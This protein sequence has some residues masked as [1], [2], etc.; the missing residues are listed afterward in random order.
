VLTTPEVPPSWTAVVLSGGRGSRLG[1]DKAAVLIDEVS[2]MN[3]VLVSLP[4]AIH[5]IVVGP[6]PRNPVRSVTVTRESPI[7]G[8]P[9]AALAAGLQL[10]T[11]TIVA[12][13]ATDMPFAGRLLARL[14][15][16]LPAGVDALMPI[17]TAGRRQPL[18]AAYRTTALRSA[19]SLLGDPNGAS[20]RALT[21]HLVVSEILIEDDTS[22]HDID[23]TGDLDRARAIMLGMKGDW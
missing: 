23:T 13:V 7:G 20:M 15:Q 4:A 16:E 11:S 14:V 18:C 19:M 21:A 8:G 12:V 3:H 6:E 22:L 10:V 2:S 17:D 1:A 5:V 9:V